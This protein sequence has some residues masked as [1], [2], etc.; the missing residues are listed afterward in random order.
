MLYRPS[1]NGWDVGT[2]TT[3]YSIAEI[4]ALAAR[5]SL[6][7]NFLGETLALADW[8]RISNRCT[9]ESGVLTWAEKGRK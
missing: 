7:A 8:R 3:G 5:V 9:Y 1:V 6:R 2:I 4:I